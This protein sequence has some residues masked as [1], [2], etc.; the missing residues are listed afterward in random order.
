V[1]GNDIKLP[2]WYVRVI[3]SRPFAV[4]CLKNLFFEPKEEGKVG[5]LIDDG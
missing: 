1:A 4:M 2:F 5:D 3:K